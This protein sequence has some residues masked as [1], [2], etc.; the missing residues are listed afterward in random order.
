MGAEATKKEIRDFVLDLGIDDVGFANI[1]D[2]SSPLSPSIDTLFPTAKSMIVMAFK[3]GSNCESPSSTMAMA[4]RLD[5]MEFT[6]SCNY[7][8]SR[9]IEKEFHTRSM[10]VPVSYPLDMGAKTNGLVGEVSLRHAALAAGL[11]AF[12]RHNLIIHPRLGTR[13]I[14]TAVLSELDL[15]SD[16]QVKDDLCTDCDICVEAC[17]AG[18]LDEEGKTQMMK[19]LRVSQ[20]HGLG[21]SISFWNKFI[22]ASPEEQIKMFMSEEFM[23]LYQAQM[24]GFQYF[25]FKCYTSCPIGQDL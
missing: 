9:F 15:P 11:G 14:F 10:S 1:K 24:I 3:E 8:V 5:L 2:Y 19:C 18:A 21:G 7:K 16:P 6:R 25:C 17:P 22:K 4:G 13:V 12:G 23:R 20:P